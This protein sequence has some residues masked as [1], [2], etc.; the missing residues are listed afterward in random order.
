[1]SNYSFNYLDMKRK[2]LKLQLKV[3]TLDYLSYNCTDSMSG[4]F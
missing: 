4:S 3:K 2:D 1:M